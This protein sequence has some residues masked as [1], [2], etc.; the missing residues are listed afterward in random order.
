MI[1][2]VFHLNKLCVSVI[3]NDMENWKSWIT[4]NRKLKPAIVIDPQSSFHTF[5]SGDDSEG[6]MSLQETIKKIYSKKMDQLQV[7][8]NCNLISM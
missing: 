7:L 3:V 5:F 2:Y 4:E 1:L 8:L 6:V